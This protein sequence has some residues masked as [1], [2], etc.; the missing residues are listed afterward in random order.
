M[1]Y[2]IL[3][4]SDNDDCKYLVQQLVCPLATSTYWLVILCDNGFVCNNISVKSME[5][6]YTVGI[7]CKHSD[8]CDH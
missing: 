2:I 4:S 5:Y 1:L 7:Q 6:P 8:I 3:S